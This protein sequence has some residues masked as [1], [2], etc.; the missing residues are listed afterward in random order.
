[1]ARKKKPRTVFVCQSCGNEFPRWFGKCSACE[2]WNT[3]V[4]MKVSTRSQKS[5]V[6]NLPAGRQGGKLGIGNV[7]VLL[8]DVKL[9]GLTRIKI[10]IEEFDRCLGC[11]FVSGQ[12]VLLAGEPGIGKSTLLLQIADAISSTRHSEFIP[13][14]SGHAQYDERDI[15]SVLYISGEES[16][17]QIK[18]RAERLGIRAEHIVLYSET[19]LDTVV[20]Q[21]RSREPSLIIIDSI[22][23]LQDES[24]VSAAGSIAQVK[25]C[26]FNLHNLAKSQ[27]IILIL[28]G[29]ITK[30]GVIA[31]PKVLEHLVDTVLYLEGEP[32][33]AYRVLRVAKNRFGSTDEIGVFEMT[34]KGLK[35]VKEPS[36]IFIKQRQND[37][38]GNSAV[39]TLKGKK[40]FLLEIQAL[41]SPSVFS[42]PKRTV[43]GFDFNRT[44][45]IAAVLDKRLNMNLHQMDIYVNVAG[46]IKIDE[47]GVDLGVALSMI[48]SYRNKP[49]KDVATFGELGLSGEIRQV[50][51]LEKRIKEAKKLGY[52]RVVGP[53][54]AKTIEEAA[55]LAIEK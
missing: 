24:V 29:H 35:Q 12:V 5:K 54:N 7:P 3:L 28:V 45:L 33:Y 4:E 40:V 51:Q 16:P 17:H 13:T 47:V 15:P 26:A 48:S 52:K 8:K 30:G 27:N 39:V 9:A 10:G 34:E 38:S 46:G 14:R 19:D 1:V 50:P 25:G 49:L 36:K 31:G 11:G 41:T 20:D 18:M 6:K 22:Q 42:Y 43:T 23:A 37:Y 55:G 21:I 32:I 44:L 2:E 53:H